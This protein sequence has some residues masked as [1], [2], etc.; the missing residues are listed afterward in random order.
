MAL[1]QDYVLRL[2]EEIINLVVRSDRKKEDILEFF[3]DSDGKD[4]EKLEYL[5]KLID[6]KKINEAEDYLFENL[7]KSNHDDFLIGM[8]FYK[9]LNLKDDSFFE[10]IN[11]ERNEIT[12]GIADL[13]KMYGYGD[14][15]EMLFKT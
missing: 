6:E 9:Y 11:Y 14:F 2:I 12:D 3:E 8:L 4:K 7:D 10:D 5:K 1:K 13:S 15:V